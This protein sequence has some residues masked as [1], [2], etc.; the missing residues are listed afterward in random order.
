MPDAKHCA[1]PAACRS[2]TCKAVMVAAPSH[3][4]VRSR[5]HAFLVVF[6]CDDED[7]LARLRAI[8]PCAIALDGQPQ[9]ADRYAERASLH[10]S[11]ALEDDL[12]A[13]QKDILAGVLRGLSNKEIGRELG[14][15]HFTVRNHVS[16]LLHHLAMPSRR[17]L[18]RALAD[19]EATF[20]RPV[21]VPAARIHTGTLPPLRPHPAELAL[22]A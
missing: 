5:R 9:G 7:A 4:D 15:S 10:P 1:E 18:R 19:Q 22:R 8:A 6:D 3:A 12:T 17:Q 16:R 21:A 20:A 13:R 14:I 11:R 2:S